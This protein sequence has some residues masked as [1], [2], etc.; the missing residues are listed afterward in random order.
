MSA[1]RVVS[2]EMAIPIG[3]EAFVYLPAGRRDRPTLSRRV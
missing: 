2:L 3:P 1:W